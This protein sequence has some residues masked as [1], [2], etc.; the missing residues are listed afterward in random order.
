[1]VPQ[2]LAAR[3][4]RF[5]LCRSQTA[6]AG[7]Y[8]SWERTTTKE[9]MRVQGLDYT[10]RIADVPISSEFDGE[11]LFSDCVITLRSTMP[12]HKQQQ[13]LWHE[14]MHIILEGESGGGLSKQEERFVTRVSN[15]LYSVLHDNNLLVPGWWERVV[16]STDFINFPAASSGR[17]RKNH[18]FRNRT[19]R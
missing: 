17:G 9:M 3:E 13:T 15:I 11:T 7:G 6:T 2:S 12:L 1:M 4:G 14:V 5:I 10:V 8:P 18:G 19:T 16:D